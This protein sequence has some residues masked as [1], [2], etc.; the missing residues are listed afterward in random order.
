MVDP[1][2]HDF[3]FFNDVW[4]T[5]SSV[6]TGITDIVSGWFGSPA[7]TASTIDPISVGAVSGA[8]NGGILG[9]F[10]NP[11]DAGP[12]GQQEQGSITS[13]RL[14]EAEDNLVAGPG[15]RPS[16]RDI[17][18]AANAVAEGAT[19]AQRSDGSNDLW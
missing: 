19:P 16:G 1:S 5:L 9:L 15:G 10:G 3:E 17:Q 8:L 7:V 2:G 14:T 6:V 18:R 4:D 11:P 12:N 13:P